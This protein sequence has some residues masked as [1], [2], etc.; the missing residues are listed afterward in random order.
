MVTRIQIGKSGITKNIV[1]E[2][3]KQL[4]KHKIVDVKFLKS[5]INGKNKKVLFEEIAAKTNALVVKK[6]GFVVTLKKKI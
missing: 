1:N 5:A 2:I 3:E 4:K 6:I